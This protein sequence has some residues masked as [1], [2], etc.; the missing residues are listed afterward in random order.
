VKNKECPSSV[1]RLTATDSFPQRGKPRESGTLAVP[2]RGKP[3]E[4]GTLAVP[5]GEAKGWGLAQS[6]VV[7][8]RIN[9]INYQFAY[10]S[11]VQYKN[12][13]LQNCPFLFAENGAISPDVP[14]GLS[15]GTYKTP[16]YAGGEK[17]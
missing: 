16:C 13:Q 11:A 4:S 5:R 15:R 7:R 8:L 10:P 3:R 1:L 12:E 14:R 9:S 6:E 2:Q 17:L